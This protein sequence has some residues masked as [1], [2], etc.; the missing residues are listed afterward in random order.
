MNILRI[1]SNTKVPLLVLD[2]KIINV[3]VIGLILLLSRQG[4]MVLVKE[5]RVVEFIL[6]LIKR[7]AKKHFGRVK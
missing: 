4:L 3:I 2:E 5:Y 1:I 6:I 7:N